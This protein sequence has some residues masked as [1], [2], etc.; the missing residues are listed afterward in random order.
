MRS[1]FVGRAKL[2]GLAPLIAYLASI[3]LFLALGL[4]NLN[5]A[6]FDTYM[7]LA[8]V[9]AVWPM[10]FLLALRCQEL[11]L[12]TIIAWLVAGDIP[13]LFELQHAFSDYSLQAVGKIIAIGDLLVP[14]AF[15]GFLR[16]RMQRRA[17]RSDKSL[18][19]LELTLF[20]FVLVGVVVVL[21]G[22]M[23]GS[24][25]VLF[26]FRFYVYAAAAV[27]TPAILN[28]RQKIRRFIMVLLAINGIAV[29]FVLVTV[30]LPDPRFGYLISS[31]FT[32]LYSILLLLPFILYNDPGHRSWRLAA[33]VAV[34]VWVITLLIDESRSHYVGLFIGVCALSYIYVR[35]RIGYS[36]HTGKPVITI[37]IFAAL[38]IVLAFV[39]GVNTFL[40]RIYARVLTVMDYS[41]DLSI[42]Y[43]LVAIRTG[44]DLFVQNPL[45][46][47]GSGQEI[48]FES[49]LR[50]PLGGYRA[51][52]L[53]NFHLRVLVTGGLITYALFALLA[54][55]ILKKCWRVCRDTR[56]DLNLYAIGAFS[57]TI[58]Y[59]IIISMT[60]FNE[61]HF[62]MVWLFLGLCLSIATVDRNNRL[63][64]WQGSTHGY[65]LPETTDSPGTSS[66]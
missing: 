49:P 27:Y 16:S 64:K 9:F 50:G 3:G 41:Q 33:F 6:S 20:A 47:I 55:I 28:T 39:F 30:Y 65:S 52:T 60:V 38:V 12:Y 37:I 17:F 35:G 48:F 45:F 57:A 1:L 14:V 26:E 42:Q 13:F 66:I 8:V 21:I 15:V 24:E 32:N 22:L 5:S 11:V 51:A 34:P 36:G 2:N 44:V 10:L 23:K 19:Y 54:G 4:Y 40:D 56:S 7:V 53:H 61:G 58:S 31:R 29:V 43:R 63:A 46:G 25:N 62:A 18:A 59:L